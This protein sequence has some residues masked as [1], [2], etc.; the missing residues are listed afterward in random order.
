M[1]IVVASCVVADRPGALPALFASVL[2]CVQ[3]RV[4]GARLAR[5][6]VIVQVVA[7]WTRY[8]S[9]VWSLTLYWTV[10]VAYSMLVLALIYTYQFKEFP[11]YWR[12]LTNF[13][14]AKYNLIR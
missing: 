6:R 5:P 14:D 12:S 8:A 11:D 4:A 7:H 10:L 3:P 2:A 9:G 1:T 13:S